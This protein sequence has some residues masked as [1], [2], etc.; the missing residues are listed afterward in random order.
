MAAIL[1][2]PSRIRAI[3]VRWSLIEVLWK[4]NLFSEIQND[5]LAEIL[6]ILYATRVCAKVEVNEN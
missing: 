3:R 2:I 5:T 6:H 4:V 1:G